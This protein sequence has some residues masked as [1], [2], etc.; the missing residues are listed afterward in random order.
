ML[1]I[2][3][4]LEWFFIGLL[5][6]LV[7]AVSLFGLFVAIQFFRNPGAGVASSK[8]ALADPKVGDHHEVVG[9]RAAD[10]PGAERL[11]RRTHEEVVDPGGRHVGRGVRRSFSAHRPPS[12]CPGS[13]PRSWPVTASSG[14]AFRSPP[15]TTG[16]STLSNDLEELGELARLVPHSPARGGRRWPITSS[17]RAISAP[18]GWINGPARRTGRAD[19]TGLSRRPH[20]HAF[21]IRATRERRR[22]GADDHP[23]GRAERA[24]TAAW[25][26]LLE[27]QDVHPLAANDTAP[28][29]RPRRGG[30]GR[31]RWR[32]GSVGSRRHDRGARLAAE[33]RRRVLELTDHHAAPPAPRGS[34]SRPG[35]SDPSTRRRTPPPAAVRPPRRSSSGRSPRDRGCRSPAAPS[36]RR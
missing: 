7:A 19:A 5:S 13:S 12:T 27:H 20:Q 29:L 15:I 6:F 17:S 18:L 14:R 30:R 9:D 8:L 10:G 21:W 34:R 1:A 26:G 28:R 23:E 31:S 11:D 3:G 36:S 35:S 4:F 16:C 32:P 22:V 25:P 2:N 33:D 24:K